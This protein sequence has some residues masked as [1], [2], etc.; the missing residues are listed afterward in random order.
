MAHQ[1]SDAMRGCIEECD[2]CHDICLE[3]ASHCL[4]EGGRHAE[5][6]HIRT[7]LDCAEACQTAANFMLRS[8]T[9]HAMT[10]NTCAEACERCAR[11][12]DA[13]SDDELMRRCAEICRSCADSCREMAGTKARGAGTTT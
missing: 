13:F 4:E 9:M 3:G 7:L 12:C 1:I 8:S 10:C 6:A 2:A 11:S 5:A